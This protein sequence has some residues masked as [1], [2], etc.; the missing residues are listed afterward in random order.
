MAGRP[1]KY[2][3]PEEMELIIDDYFNACMHNWKVLNLKN[4]HEDMSEMTT[5]RH[6][7]VSGLCL[8]LN[9]SRQGLKEYGDKPEFS[10]TVKKGKQR[11]EAHLEQHLY[12]NNVTGAIFNLKN[13]FKWKDK[14]ETEV[15]HD[16]SA[17]LLEFFTEIDGKS[18]GLPD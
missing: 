1:V 18:D 14:H 15:K 12:G 7:T 2:K 6:P 11:I 9:L 8:A 17:E 10:D 5:D 3:T 13:N 4:F 16:M